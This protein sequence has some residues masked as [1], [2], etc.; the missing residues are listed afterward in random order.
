MLLFSLEISISDQVGFTYSGMSPE[1]AV[2][3]MMKALEAAREV[4]VTMLSLIHI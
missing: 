2:G 4:S 1:M 3:D